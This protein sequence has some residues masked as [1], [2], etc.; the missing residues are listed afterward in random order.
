MARPKTIAS[1]YVQFT[2][3][4]PPELAAVIRA[5]SQASGTP[6]N[7]EIIHALC[8]GLGLSPKPFLVAVAY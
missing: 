6:M 3:K 7:T 1:T 4:L 5:R 2:M 8:K